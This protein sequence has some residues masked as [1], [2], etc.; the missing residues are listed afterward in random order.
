MSG[1]EPVEFGHTGRSHGEKRDTMARNTCLA[2]GLVLVGAAAGAMEFAGVTMPD[3][4]T[5]NGTTLKLNGMRVRKKLFIKVYVG[6][7]YLPTASRD[8][9]AIIA[10]DEPKEVVMHFPY[11]KV[12]KEKLIKAWQ[13]GL[14][15]KSAANL[16]ALQA[17]LDQF[18]TLWPDMLHRQNAVITYVPG[19]GTALEINGAKASGIPGA[20][21]AQ[22][23][24]AVWLGAKP[25][26]AG[27][28]AAML[29]H[30]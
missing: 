9:A 30:P 7:L 4:V 12:S 19:T 13:E 29:G 26:D 8:A 1:P 27:L 6:G 28:K 15:N 3:T 18:C 11:S 16:P 25:A 2:V 5:A 14:A 23:L 22:A 20:D 17:R 10:A 24:F 21:F